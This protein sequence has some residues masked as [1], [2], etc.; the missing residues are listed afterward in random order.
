MGPVASKSFPG[1]IISK[2]VNIIGE[3][4]YFI[5]TDFSDTDE[6]KLIGY[7]F[8]RFGGPQVIV[9]NGGIRSFIRYTPPSLP[10]LACQ[11]P[12]RF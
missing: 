1:K 11:L 2:E 9:Q 4:T 12:L 10:P 6:T 3:V 8:P 5:A 7:H